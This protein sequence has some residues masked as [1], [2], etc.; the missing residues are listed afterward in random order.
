[1]ALS[2]LV[3]A[4]L[5]AQITLQDFSTTEIPT[6]TYFYGTW[7]QNGSLLG[8]ATPILGMVQGSGVYS[9]TNAAATNSDSAGLQIYF[10]AP[11]ILTGVEYL[12]LTAQALSSNTAQSFVVRLQDTN[13]ATGFAAFNASAF[14]NGGYSTVIQPLT[15]GSLNLGAVESI[16]ITGNIDGG[17]RP[18]NFSFDTL[19]GLSASQVIPEP[20]TYALI[21]T[22]LGLVG[23]AIRRRA[24]RL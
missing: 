14:P 2:A 6:L 8:S 16:F 17:V 20:S 15:I 12:S 19:A 13:G 9:V 3:A 18:F 23:F 21:A 1:M 7:A 22:G 11:M 5:S 24:L 4:P 10:P